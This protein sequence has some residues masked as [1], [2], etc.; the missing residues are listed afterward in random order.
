MI[1]CVCFDASHRLSSRP[2][3]HFLSAPS[4]V[5]P[6][7]PHKRRAAFLCIASRA[8]NGALNSPC[9][10]PGLRRGGSQRIEG[11]DGCF[12]VRDH[13]PNSASTPKAQCL[14]LALL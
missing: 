2:S 1:D 3:P 9:L 12:A 6:G 11:G 13:V 8:R 7:S 5:P 10:Q 14:T 4:T